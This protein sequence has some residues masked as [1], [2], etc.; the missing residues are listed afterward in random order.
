MSEDLRARASG[1]ARPN[2]SNFGHLLSILQN[3]AVSS[4]EKTALVH[5]G[6]SLCYRDL[7]AAAELLAGKL[8]EAEITA[9][10][11]VGLIASNTLEYLS[12]FFAV[13]RTGAI[14]VPI[15][16]GSKRDEISDLAGQI[17]LNAFCY[18][19]NF[20][21]LIPDGFM[22]PA[23]QAP[24]LFDGTLAIRR[25]AGR[26]AVE[27]EREMFLKASVGMIRF[28]SGTTGKAKGVI[29]S[30]NAIL[31]RAQTFGRAYSLSENC[32]VLHLLSAELATPTLLGCIW[33]STRVVFEEIHR[34]ESIARLIRIHGVTHIHASPLFYGMMVGSRAIDADDLRSVRYVISTGAPLPT[35]VANAFRDKFGREIFQYYALAE[36]G[37]VF[38]STSQDIGKRGSSGVLLPG[39][40]VKLVNSSRSAE[41]EIGELLVR[42]S[43]LFEGYYRPWRVGGEVLEDGWF[44]TGDVARRDAEGYYW[45]IGRTKDVINVGGVKVF[46]DEIEQVLLRHP[47]VDEAVVFGAPDA[48]FGEV[49]RA[50]V[51]L[52]SGS[53]CTEKELIDFSNQR[54]SVFK[55]LRSIEIVP[56]LP[57]TAT[58]KLKRAPFERPSGGGA[59]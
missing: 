13:A 22:A 5:D 34:L 53:A 44:R 47:T 35:P 39:C 20:A 11:T 45:I 33:Q 8:V 24:A 37:T 36:C 9:G 30:T 48:R 32:C 50:R 17:G 57:K 52:F 46:P 55:R 58:G 4:A 6:R 27:P 21:R 31:A 59:D 18:S 14:V 28:S 25:R 40:D 15:P 49:P 2:T 7:H 51:A 56:E 43:G 38:A 10:D 23:V 41:G 1:E 26:K 3:A 42:G 54:L 16:R 19:R 29:L 12:M